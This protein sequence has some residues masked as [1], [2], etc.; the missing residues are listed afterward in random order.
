MAKTVR[1]LVGSLRKASVARK[2]AKNVIPMFP[3]GWD[4][5]IVE[6]GDLPLYNND[7]D[8]PAVS[9]RPLPESYTAFRNEMKAA[10]AVLFVTPENNRLV[11][12]CLKNAID[13]CSKPNDDVALLGKPGGVI[14]H[15]IGKMGGY[16]SQKS[17]K[18]ACSYFNMQF[19]PQPEAFIGNS[20]QLFDEGSDSINNEGTIAFLQ[21]YVDMVVNLVK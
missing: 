13:I 20:H 17:L 1:V 15:S 11:P 10:D 19:P 7:Y 6:I 14:S 5:Q 9:D 21:K 16:S 4:V 18:L 12:A 3:E 8:N 2:I